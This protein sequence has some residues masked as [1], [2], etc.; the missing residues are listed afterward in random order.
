MNKMTQVDENPRD[1]SYLFFLG[2][3]DKDIQKTDTDSYTAIVVGKH[4]PAATV[5]YQTG[6]A[7][8]SFIII[9]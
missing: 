8:E 2:Q 4:I 7:F 1:K 5:N 6:F 9:T 3:A